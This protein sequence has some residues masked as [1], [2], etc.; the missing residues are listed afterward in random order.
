MLEHQA[1][2][3]V[4][5][6]SLADAERHLADARFGLVLLGV[7]DASSLAGVRRKHQLWC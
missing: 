1:A 5:V 4:H 6:C 7:P 2:D 3:A